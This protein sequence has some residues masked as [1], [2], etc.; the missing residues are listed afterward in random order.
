MESVDCWPLAIILARHLGVVPD[1]Y[2]ASAVTS[3]GY[4]PLEWRM[5]QGPPRSLSGSNRVVTVA[6]RH[7]GNSVGA[8]GWRPG[9]RR[10]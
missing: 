4:P 5:L 1:W 3:E 7:L 8:I 9:T 6:D 2:P 10:S